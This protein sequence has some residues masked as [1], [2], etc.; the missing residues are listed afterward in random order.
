M[1]QVFFKTAAGTACSPTLVVIAIFTGIFSVEQKHLR[2]P[3]GR[4]TRFA[5]LKTLFNAR[6]QDGCAPFR[7]EEEATAACFQRSWNLINCPTNDQCKNQ[8]S[9]DHSELLKCFISA[10]PEVKLLNLVMKGKQRKT[11][12]IFSQRT[13]IGEENAVTP[14]KGIFSFLCGLRGTLLMSPRDVI[15][16]GWRLMT[17]SSLQQTNL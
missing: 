8:G 14:H 4:Q 1:C 2:A 13:F 10:A 15:T 9:H 16:G 5:H 3:F 17:A 12:T 11:K 7:E 6:W